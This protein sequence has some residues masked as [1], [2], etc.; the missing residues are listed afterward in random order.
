MENQKPLEEK[1][2]LEKHTQEGKFNLGTALIDID[3]R[4]KTLT[5][6]ANNAHEAL[7]FLA[8]WYEEN[9]VNKIQEVKPKIELL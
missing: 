1:T 5:E 2:I 6:R 9:A 7:E 8:K 3:S 4:I